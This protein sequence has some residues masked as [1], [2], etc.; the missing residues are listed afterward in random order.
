MRP[1]GPMKSFLNSC[2]HSSPAGNAELKAM[3][4]AI[5]ACVLFIG[6][7]AAVQRVVPQ[8]DRKV[9]KTHTFPP[10]PPLAVPDV[11]TPQSPLPPDANAKFRIVPSSFRGINFQTRSYGT[12]DFSSGKS[13]DLVLI[14]GKF[15]E[16]RTSEQH[17]FDLNDVFYTDL[18]GD[19]RPE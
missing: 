16:F 2:N 12:Y 3:L 11:R 14:D 15:R 8:N 17:W 7:L 5:G 13:R 10:P 6:F 9:I 19:G 4:F 18:T 1:I